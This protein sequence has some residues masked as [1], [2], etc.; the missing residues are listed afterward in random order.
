M[1]F[2]TL[3]L[4]VAIIGLYYQ[5]RTHCTYCRHPVFVVNKFSHSY[6]PYSAMVTSYLLLKCICCRGAHPYANLVV[7]IAWTIIGWV[8]MD[9][10]HL[11]YLFIASLNNTLIHHL[12]MARS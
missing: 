9:G 3:S 4:V 7:I 11:Y 12:S 2:G 6:S 8:S 1:V 10:H 5:I